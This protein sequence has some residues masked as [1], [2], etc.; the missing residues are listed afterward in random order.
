[1]LHIKS[2]IAMNCLIN[3]IINWANGKGTRAEV[4]RRYLRIKYHM[5]ID[6]QAL[7]RRINRMGNKEVNLA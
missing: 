7:D 1:M 6:P 4:V 2:A 5:N 3:D